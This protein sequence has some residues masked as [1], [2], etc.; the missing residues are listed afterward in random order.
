MLCCWPDLHVTVTWPWCLLCLCQTA[1]LG[2]VV[3]STCTFVIP[4]VC[5]SV[6]KLLNTVFCQQINRRW[7][8]AA[9]VVHRP[10]TWTVIFW[11][12]EVK[13]Q[14]HTQG[15]KID[16]EALWR[17]SCERVT[18]LVVDMLMWHSCVCKLCVYMSVWFCVYV[19][20]SVCLCLVDLWPEVC[21]S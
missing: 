14:V 10:S 20:L 11:G 2:S 3:L 6:T 9:L 8:K 7:C 15:P 13:V 18:S 5:S 17:T 21:Q 12:Q 16:L 19:C 4:L 1:R